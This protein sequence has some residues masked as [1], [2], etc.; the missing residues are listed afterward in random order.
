MNK[1]DNKIH[2]SYEE[3]HR[4]YWLDLMSHRELSEKF[5][6]HIFDI[7]EIL[8]HFSIPKRIGG[9]YNDGAERFLQ[10]SNSGADQFIWIIKDKV[11]EKYIPEHLWVVEREMGIKLNSESVIR[12]RDGNL[13]NNHPLNLRV[14]DNFV[15]FEQCSPSLWFYNHMLFAIASSNNAYCDRLRVGCVITNYDLDCVYSYGYN[16]N[17]K[18]LANKCDSEEAGKCGCIHAEI[19][20]LLKV[21]QDDKN[22]VMFCTHS[23][24]IAC[25]KAII[26]SGFKYL[27]YERI[28]RD[29]TP[30]RILNYYGIRT[31]P[32]PIGD[33]I[34]DKDS[35]LKK[36]YTLD[37][38]S[39]EKLKH[40]TRD[41]FVA[42]NG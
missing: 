38:F 33:V 10:Q 31:C 23:P 32:Y 28:Y 8:K 2:I 18:G 41:K 26:N 7:D 34:R 16:G 27:Y 22:K 20:A 36:K 11:T 4:A 40:E 15:D 29:I 37:T 6:I 25:A 12:H 9:G 1:E 17:A 24:C 5:N 13:L 19:N 30:L 39:F 21:R 35:L 42:E 14:V 3:L